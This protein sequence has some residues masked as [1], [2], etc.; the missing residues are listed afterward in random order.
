MLIACL[1][2][3]L[4]AY[5]YLTSF[6]NFSPPLS[7]PEAQSNEI[8]CLGHHTHPEGKVKQNSK[9]YKV[10]E[11]CQDQRTEVESACGVWERIR[12]EYLNQLHK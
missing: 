10:H 9:C 1:P 3:Y 5:K 12:K 6:S 2:W 8:I 11:S 7:K 4:D